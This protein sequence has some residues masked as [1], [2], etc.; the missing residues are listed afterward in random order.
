MSELET[1]NSETHTPTEHQQGEQQELEEEIDKQSSTKKRKTSVGKN[2]KSKAK[3]KA[4]SET[5][6]LAQASRTLKACELCRKQK[7]R[8]FRSPDH[9]NSCLRCRFINKVCSFEG[10]AGNNNGNNIINTDI[11][12]GDQNDKLNLIL[13]KV[14]EIFRIVKNDNN[15][16]ARLLLDAASSMQNN[17]GQ[18]LNSRSNSVSNVEEI[19]PI[20]PDF[21]TLNSTSISSPF[22]LINNH[23]QGKNLCPS[24]ISNLFIA[25]PDVLSNVKHNTLLDLGILTQSEV[26]DLVNDF[27]RNY[28]R[29]VSFP[30]KIP[31]DILVEEIKYKSP[32]LLTTCCCISLRYSLDDN[33]DSSKQHHKFKQL[34]NVLI[35][36][37][38]QSFLRYTSFAKNDYGFIEF[39][40]S[41]VVLSI[42]SSSISTLV[43]NLT[44]ND[45]T[46]DL[47]GFNLDPYQLSS[48]GITSF[49][50]KS[51]FQTFRSVSETSDSES[52]T[53]IRIYNHLCLVHVVNCLF[54]GRMC[55]LDDTRI[56]YC[57]SALSLF[58]ATNFDGRMCSEIN[59]LYITY[60]YLQQQNSTDLNQIKQNFKTTQQE[61]E[62]WLITWDYLFQQPALQFV[63]FNYNF[64]SMLI[65]FIFCFHKEI[66]NISQDEF[67]FERLNQS[68]ELMRTAL[69]SQEPNYLIKMFEF[70][71]KVLD[72]VENI[73]NDSYFA[74]LS[75]Q[76]HFCFYFTGIILILILRIIMDRQDIITDILEE[77]SQKNLDFHLSSIYKLITKFE[78]IS[79][80]NSKKDIISIYI[81]GLE[82]CLEENF[83]SKDQSI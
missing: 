17:S 43:S 44:I 8:C 30:S 72:H 29:W 23:M 79:M 56:K 55:I 24:T 78:N 9:P 83:Y 74:Y 42:Y 46:N 6:R 65:L 33:M 26:I 47:M 45:S 2:A 38:N 13:S 80:I 76:I 34:I 37:L 64:C 32:L 15:E 21:P 59:I 20:I 22:A 67:S 69:L 4:E 31:T 7:T 70:G 62:D 40:Q 52:L 53:K 16:D 27:R 25:S 82:N 66:V 71:K 75:D 14:S 68:P 50:T 51:T 36:D 5:R 12:S 41:L 57:N 58:N 61:I 77:F 49:L 1:T 48:I 60:K 35:Q 81:A 18:G 10:E 3:S 54:S 28:G 73:N 63:E 39:L 11:I 19:E